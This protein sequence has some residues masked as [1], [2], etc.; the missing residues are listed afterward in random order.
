YDAP[1]AAE[2]QRTLAVIRTGPK[3]GFYFDVFRSRATQP[4]PGDFHDYLYHNMGQSLSVSGPDGGPLSLA[5]SQTLATQAGLL[6][7]YTYFK[8]ERSS[9]A[10][11]DFRATFTV[12]LAGGSE[13]V[14]GLWMPGSVDRRVFTLD[15]PQ[16]R[17]IRTAMA[18]EFSTMPMPTLL[19]RQTGDAWARP[20]VGVF[21]PYIGTEGAS[22]RTVRALPG[23]DGD[24][25]PVACVVEGKDYSAFLAQDDSE[26]PQPRVREGHTFQGAFGVVLTRNGAASELYLGRGMQLGSGNIRVASAGGKPVS[27]SLRRNSD[28]KGWQYSAD[29]AITVT[30]PGGKPITLPVAQ[31]KPVRGNGSR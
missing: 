27:A 8:N 22:I 9:D 15:A 10:T 12:K 21:E 1:V 18:P 6:K 23:R 4:K 30:L 16:N 19:V 20:F 13:R 17:A 31:D 25:G 7:G 29:G 14:M 26:V 2:Q 3:S 24:G 5:P 11:G 28:G